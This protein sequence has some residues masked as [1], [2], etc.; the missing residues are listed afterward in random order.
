MV[1]VDKQLRWRVLFSHFRHPVRRFSRLIGR[2]LSVL[3]HQAT[4]LLRSLGMENIMRVRKVAEQSTCSM[5]TLLRCG[6]HRS[7]ALI[8]PLT[9]TTPP[10]HCSQPNPDVP[11]CAWRPRSS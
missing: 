2:C 4:V 8:R 3:L 11:V 6:M 7:R 1:G 10:S 9:P 5:R